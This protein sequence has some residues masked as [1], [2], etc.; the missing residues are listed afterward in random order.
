VAVRRGEANAERFFLAGLIH[1]VGRLVMYLR[2]PDASREVLARS[3]AG[4]APVWRVER[5]V[6]GFDH[7]AVGRILCD[8]WRLPPSC[9]EAV[10]YHHT[11]S[12]AR[13]FPTE[14]AAVHV[15]DVIAVALAI[16]N[17]GEQ[18]VPGFD[19]DAWRT[20]GLDPQSTP[21][22]LEDVRGHLSGLAHLLP[23]SA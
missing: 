6:F 21:V 3:R 5:D 2:A 22:L 9:I 20:L 7:A 14:S 1:D 13:D 17:S 8:E 4:T 12:V 11:P 23:R 18:R 10:G 15:G 19:V 16:G